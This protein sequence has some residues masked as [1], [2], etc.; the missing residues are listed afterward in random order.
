MY[1]T[2]RKHTDPTNELRQMFGLHSEYLR[3]NMERQRDLI[4]DVDMHSRSFITSELSVIESQKQTVE[5]L[6]SMYTGAVFAQ[7]SELASYKANAFA[8]FGVLVAIVA[9]I[10][11]DF[12]FHSLLK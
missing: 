6:I 1:R 2:I 11:T 12:R 5:R 7:Q 3:L 10:L 9:V 4:T 8:G